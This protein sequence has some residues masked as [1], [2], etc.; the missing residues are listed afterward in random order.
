MIIMEK[1]VLEKFPEK[2][3]G[4]FSEIFRKFHGK[5]SRK[6]FGTSLTLDDQIQLGTVDPLRHIMK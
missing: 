3:V 5:F 4:K 1:Y 2:L 6:C